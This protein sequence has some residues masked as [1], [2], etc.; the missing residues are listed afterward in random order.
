MVVHSKLKQDRACC[1]P[2]GTDI[3][4]KNV[5]KKIVIYVDKGSPAEK[6]LRSLKGKEKI[7]YAYNKNSSAPSASYKMYTVKK[8]DSLWSIAK[9]QLG[10]GSRYPEIVTLNKLGKKA[11]KPGQKLKLPKK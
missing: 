9:K 1:L 8:G 11:I 3:T 6:Y 5:H 7:A 10:K 2:N 4:A